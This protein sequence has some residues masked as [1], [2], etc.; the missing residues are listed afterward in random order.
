MHLEVSDGLVEL[1]T[2]RLRNLSVEIEEERPGRDPNVLA[3]EAEE[4]REQERVLREALAEDQA[5]LNLAV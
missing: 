4:L 2:E 3:A 5:R 1:A